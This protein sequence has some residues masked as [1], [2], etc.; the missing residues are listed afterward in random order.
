MEKYGEKSF[1]LAAVAGLGKYQM[2]IYGRIGVY[3]PRDNVESIWYVRIGM[4]TGKYIAS[5]WITGII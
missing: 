5:I 4:Q 2:G 1:F 3:R